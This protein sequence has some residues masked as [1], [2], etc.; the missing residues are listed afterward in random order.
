MCAAPLFANPDSRPLPCHPDGPSAGHVAVYHATR[1]WHERDVSKCIAAALKMLSRSFHQF[2][3]LPPC[4]HAVLRLPAQDF[5]YNVDEGIE[6]HNLWSTKPLSSG[7]LRQARHSQLQHPDP[8]LDN[9]TV[10]AHGNMRMH[11]YLG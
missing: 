7:R 10:A 5:P 3:S 2:S 4:A 6:H 9:L 1:G 8:G 11:S